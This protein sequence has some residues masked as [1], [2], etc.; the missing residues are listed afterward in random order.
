MGGSSWLADNV[1][2]KNISPWAH[3][4]V[5]L[6]I[7]LCQVG[8]S[9]WKLEECNAIQ[10]EL[11]SWLQKGISDKEGIFNSVVYLVQSCFFLSLFFLNTYWMPLLPIDLLLGSEEGKYIWS[12][13]LKAT[14]DRTRRLTEEYSDA[15]LQIFPDKVQVWCLLITSV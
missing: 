15:L 1:G 3:P 12:L 8:L 14:L 9:G 6:N 11:L 13:R 10:N 5:A 4:L 2:S 7:G